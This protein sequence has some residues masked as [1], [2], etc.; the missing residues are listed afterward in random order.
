MKIGNLFFGSEGWGMIHGSEFK[1]FMGRDNKPGFSINWT[2]M[3]YEGAAE[4]ANRPFEPK[5]WVQEDSVQRHF[6]DF[7][8]AVRSR[9]WQDLKA[10]V[11]EGYMS[12]ALC[13]LGNISFRLGRT[14]EFDSHGERFVNDDQANGLLTRRYRPPFSIPEEV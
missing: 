6:E 14:V 9:R 4:A 5:P 8:A 2:Q 13:H 1:T 7:I 12:S 3:D 11:L 10:D